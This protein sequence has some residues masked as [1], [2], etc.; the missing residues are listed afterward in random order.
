MWVPMI[1]STD[2]K[3][4]AWLDEGTTTFNENQARKEFYETDRGEESDRGAYFRMARSDAELP[5]MRRADYYHSG[6]FGVASYAK[7]ATVLEALKAVL[8]E[9][10]F[11]E[12]FRAFVTEWRYRHPYPWDL[13]RTFERVS[14]RDLDPFWRSWYYETWTLDQAVAD[15]RASDDGVLVIVED[16]GRVPMPVLL[17]V[18]PAGGETVTERVEAEAW[19][20]DGGTARLEVPVVLPESARGEQVRVEIDLE[21]R[22][23]DVDRSNNTWQGVPGS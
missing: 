5:M 1:L 12:A 3:R 15:V 19:L 4:Y 2:E 10:T 13:F 22:L 23:P 16:R 6:T 17:A 21:G 18:T 14:D 11:R 20:E 7:P 8:G 9:E